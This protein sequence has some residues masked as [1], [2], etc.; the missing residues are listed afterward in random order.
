MAACEKAEDERD[1]SDRE[2]ASWRHS[3]HVSKEG[4]LECHLCGEAVEGWIENGELLRMIVHAHES[5]AYEAQQIVQGFGLKV[6]VKNIL[7]VRR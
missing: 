7:Y 3:E 4:W 5:R 6:S 2:A 1:C